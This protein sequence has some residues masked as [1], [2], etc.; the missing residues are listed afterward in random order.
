MNSFTRRLIAGF[1][2]ICALCSA[3]AG[4]APTPPRS[5]H[6]F[7]ADGFKAP[8]RL[9]LIDRFVSASFNQLPPKSEIT[10]WRAPAMDCVS[11]IVIPDGPPARR[12]NLLQDELRVISSIWSADTPGGGQIV[13]ADV[14]NTLLTLPRSPLPLRIIIAAD[15]R[16][17]PTAPSAAAYAMSD[18]TFPGDLL[19]RAGNNVYGT[20]HYRGKLAG[21]TAAWLL[22]TEEW[23]TLNFDYRRAV[24]RSWNLFLH[25]TGTSLTAFQP[26]V[27][28]VIQ[29]ALAAAPRTIAPVQEIPEFNR[30]AML[31]I[32]N[33]VR[34]SISSG[35]PRAVPVE[36]VSSTEIVK[37]FAEE[38][39]A[40]VTV[41]T[42]MQQTP[43]DHIAIAIVWTSKP[44][45]NSDAKPS[46]IDIWCTLTTGEQVF[47]ERPRAG[48]ARLHRDVRQP[49]SSSSFDEN[50][51]Q[52]A[53]V[54]TISHDR[55]DEIAELCLNAFESDG[56]VNGKILLQW[57]GR[58]FEKDFAF[59][60]S[61]RGDR[62]RHYFNRAHHEAWLRVDLKAMVGDALARN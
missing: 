34:Q 28:G 33:A 49:A 21:A 2:F 17:L 62:A 7:I 58:R 23:T 56:A 3:L 36:E 51:L 42:V 16:Y 1:V 25:E 53:E 18:E 61:V 12:R 29:A 26:G 44:A 55:L 8:N 47:F 39:A 35:P 6:L 10:F 59:G 9:L 32:P 57:H 46:D 24:T 52:S 41:E 48:P 11:R 40:P 50:W 4:E 13:M 15:P 20:E 31:R 43:A 54:L 30:V 45:G 14:I 38:D 60:A 22:P 37:P 5:Y 27:A 19:I